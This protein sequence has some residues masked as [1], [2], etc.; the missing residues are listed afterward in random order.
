MA[1]SNVRHPF[2]G[3]ASRY[4]RVDRFWCCWPGCSEP[5]YPPLPLCIAH[6][7]T[8][9]QC[10]RDRL[11]TPKSEPEPQPGL[12]GYV[13]YLMVGPATVKIG[14]TKYLTSRLNNLRT[15]LQYVVAIELGGRSVERERHRQF[16]DERIGRR[17]DFRLSDRLKAHIDALGPQ[18]DELIKAATTYPLQPV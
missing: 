17:E 1:K 3:D 2:S 12:A 10:V 6:A 5:Q 9:A 14:T 11:A 7:L 16:A 4:Q 8:T 13:Y 15:D 18:R